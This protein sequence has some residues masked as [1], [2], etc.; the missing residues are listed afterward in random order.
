[1]CFALA[2]VIAGAIFVVI[3]IPEGDDLFIYWGESLGKFA[4][5][6]LLALVPL[7]ILYAFGCWAVRGFKATSSDAA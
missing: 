3:S 1:M 6:Y 4:T 5:L 7:L 2:F